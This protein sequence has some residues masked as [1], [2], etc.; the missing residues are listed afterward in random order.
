VAKK[1]CLYAI[2][3]LYATVLMMMMMQVGRRLGQSQPR[4]SRR[5]WT[6]R[7]PSSQSLPG[8]EAFRCW[9]AEDLWPV[10]PFSSHS[11]YVHTRLTYKLHCGCINTSVVLSYISVAVELV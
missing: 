10:L 6:L 9:L 1:Y 4:S 7:V 5:R 2:D 11:T 3:E 8:G